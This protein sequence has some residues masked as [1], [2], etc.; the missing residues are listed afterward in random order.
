M[1]EPSKDQRV[2]SACIFHVEQF[3]E[4]QPLENQSFYREFCHTQQFDDFITKRAY[5]PGQADVIFFNQSI[6]AKKNRSKIKMK[7]V[8]TPFLRSLHAHK[9]LHIINAIQPNTGNI[10]K[11]YSFNYPI[12]P[13]KLNSSLFG[14]PRPIPKIINAEFDRQ[15]EL[16][17]RLRSNK[18][19][20]A[21]EKEEFIDADPSPKVA[22]YTL[23]FLLYA[24]TAGLEFCKFA[25]EKENL[26]SIISKDED[27]DSI[28]LSIKSTEKSWN[29]QSAPQNECRL[30]MNNADTSKLD[31]IVLEMNDNGELHGSISSIDSIKIDDENYVEN[32]EDNRNRSVVSV[33]INGSIN[34]SVEVSFQSETEAKVGSRCDLCNE[35]GDDEFDLKI[36]EKTPKSSNIKSNSMHSNVS[37]SPIKNFSSS[38]IKSAIN[39]TEREEARD[40]AIAQLDLAFD[41]LAVM[42]KQNIPAEPDVYKALIEASGR[43]GDTSRATEL[44]TKLNEE[45]IVPDTVLQNFFLKA[46]SMQNFTG[47]NYLTYAPS[48]AETM[49]RLG[50]IANMSLSKDSLTKKSDT[51]NKR[52]N[53]ISQASSLV[54]NDFIYAWVDYGTSASKYSEKQKEDNR[55]KTYYATESIATQL[56]VGQSN[57]EQLYPNLKIETSIDTCP[58]CALASLSEHDI[59]MGWNPCNV[60]DYTVACPQ[61]TKRFVPHFSVECK[62][63][64]FMG[65]QGKNTPL[66]CEFL[67]PWVL[68]KELESILSTPDGIENMLKP[69]WRR[70]ADINATIWWNLILTFSRYRLP[71]TFLLQGSVQNRLIAP[72]PS[73]RI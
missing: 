6:D 60:Q 34:D 28:E 18:E 7:K 15:E 17:A 69:K 35:G 57:L 71:I 37:P 38:M 12:W 43:C 1:V 42:C 5:D 53:L 48:P 14:V 2:S 27:D 20:V 26:N 19:G 67:S 9:Q 8:E 31:D 56:L 36:S 54:I 30:P 72:S 39:Y 58:H 3:I 66:Y 50:Y 16:A 25:E 13:K 61:C 10:P 68:R 51:P 45:G 62:S 4:S 29:S 40:V 23:F 63:P 32:N 46:F 64:T 11:N 44:M 70:N 47:L 49:K 33:F 73:E 59:V 52:N 55:K 41:I 21:N 65:S 24:P 22:S